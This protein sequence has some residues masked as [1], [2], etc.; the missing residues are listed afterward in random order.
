MYVKYVA[1]LTMFRDARVLRSPAG[2]NV[3]R[4]TMYRDARVLRSPTTRPTLFSRVLHQ[5][6]YAAR[7]E[8]PP[9]AHVRGLTLI[10]R[11]SLHPCQKMVLNFPQKES[12]RQCRLHVTSAQQ[13]RRYGNPDLRSKHLR[14]LDRRNLPPSEVNVWQTGK[15]EQDVIAKN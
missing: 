4:L 15:S 14:P 5:Q 10:L 6:W 13:T 9:V 11:G 8:H 7:V 12:S 1:H 2:Q 3:A